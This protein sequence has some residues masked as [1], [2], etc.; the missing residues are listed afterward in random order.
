[1]PAIREWKV[2]KVQMFEVGQSSRYHCILAKPP[3]NWNTIT[4]ATPFKDV[5]TA[6]F[7]TTLGPASFYEPMQN[8]PDVTQLRSLIHPGQPRKVKRTRRMVKR[9]FVIVLGVRVPFGFAKHINLAED[10]VPAKVTHTRCLFI[11]LNYH[12]VRKKAETKFVQKPSSGVLWT[13]IMTPAPLGVGKGRYGSYGPKRIHSQDSVGNW[14]KFVQWRFTE[15]AKE[16][17]SQKHQ[18]HVSWTQHIWK[19]VTHPQ[20]SGKEVAGGRNL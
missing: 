8:K 11:Q 7:S 4:E 5:S 10:L 13:E 15:F 14:P 6:G 20:S 3:S 17:N 9:W 18:G 12:G 19:G 1:M 2:V 16:A